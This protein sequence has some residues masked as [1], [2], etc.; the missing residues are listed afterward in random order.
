MCRI[1]IGDVEHPLPRSMPGISNHSFH[2]LIREPSI[3]ALKALGPHSKAIFT[4]WKR[5]LSRLSIEPQDFLGQSHLDFD[6]LSLA[7]R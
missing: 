1:F 5:E 6:L 2:S 3:K 7:T 4:Q